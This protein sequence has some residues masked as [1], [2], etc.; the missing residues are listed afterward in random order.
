MLSMAAT[1]LAQAE[2]EENGTDQVKPTNLSEVSDAKPTEAARPVPSQPE[3]TLVDKII[4]S[5]VFI[6]LSILAVL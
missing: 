5:P 6:L 3:R 1:A 4:G 2:G